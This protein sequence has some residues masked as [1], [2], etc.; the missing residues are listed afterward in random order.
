LR[1]AG[2]LVDQRPAGR[3][4]GLDARRLDV[5]GRHR[6]G[7]VDRE[8]DAGLTFGDSDGGLWPGDRQQQPGDTGE[9]ED[10]WKVAAESWSL[11]HDLVEQGEVLEA[12]GVGPAALPARDVE[13]DQQ[14]NREQ[15]D[16]QP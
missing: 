8:H 6:S 12:N 1:V 9:E 16:Q 7:Y 2:Q 14:R 10:R 13:T 11:A 3:D 15:A 5:G 4:G